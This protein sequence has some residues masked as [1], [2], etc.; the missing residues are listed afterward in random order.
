LGVHERFAAVFDDAPESIAVSRGMIIAYTNPACAQLFGAS[1]ALAL[2][3]TSSLDRIA[4]EAREM[5]I[6]FARRRGA[7]SSVPGA[8]RTR[9]LR[10]DG[11]TFEM[12]VRSLPLG[13]DLVL[14]THRP[15]EE[16]LRPIATAALGQD[17]Y[18]AVFDLNL[19]IK[20]L[21]DPSTG[22]I[23]D[24][25][26]AAVDF[27]G[28]SL[29]ELRGKL[30]SD[31]NILTEEEL[32]AEMLAAVSGRR[33]YFRFRHRIASGEV[34]AVEVY[35]SPIEIND[36]RLLFSIIHD[37]TE[38]DALEQQL[39]ASQRLE[40]IGSLA[41]GIAHEFNNLLTVMLNASTLM[42]RHVDESSPLH[43]LVQDTHFAA[44]RAAQLT[45]EL[46]AFSRR[47]LMQPRTLDLNDV[48]SE[49][50][51]VLQRTF[52]ESITVVT[53]LA[54]DLP[55]T[56]IDPR[57]LEQVLMNLLLNARDAMPRGGKVVI[58]TAEFEGTPPG[59]HP[60]EAGRWIL[61]SV[62]D[63]GVGMDASIQA[64]I[65]EPLFTTKAPGDG[66]GLGLAT[67]YGIVTQS[68]GHVHVESA[69]GRGTTIGIHL[70]VVD[71]PPS[72]ILPA[73]EQVR[74][75]SRPAPG[76]RVLLVEDMA[77]VR[78]TIVRELVAAGL[79]VL[80]AASAEEAEE[81]LATEL[82]RLDVLVT[83]IV[84][85]GAS[86]IDLAERTLARRPE[87]P[88]VVI[89][90][91]LRGHDFGRLPRTVRALQKPFTG[92]HLLDQIAAVLAAA[93]HPSAGPAREP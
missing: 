81:L 22:R 56:R 21:I 10:L 12:E 47:Q 64:H 82:D 19:A 62:A 20:L 27:Y 86:G 63:D 24:A 50:A 36:R 29:A 32:K 39:R 74:I 13:R 92:E 68:G 61:L 31:L 87:L 55:P 40:A 79:V 1:S 2:V 41:G 46:L 58:R 33:G 16:D 48:V 3:G 23:V 4:T 70:P 37:V 52:G 38:R 72:G 71:E 78:M 54:N 30:I 11:T 80:E 77:S 45:R 88:I 75:P 34:R 69:P 43:P 90:G 76:C 26:R 67:V 15:I 7:G 57:Q 14:V 85:P 65:F 59:A 35:S 18:R 25:N 49:L 5:I 44:Q 93:A 66:T 73:D 53:E 89:S 8:Y 17:F 51:G 83:D 9:G 91:D 6:E 42:R 60:E 28:Y 84:M